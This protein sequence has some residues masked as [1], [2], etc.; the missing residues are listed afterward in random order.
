MD[1]IAENPDVPVLYDTFE[2]WGDLAATGGPGRD[3]P[4]GYF[5]TSLSDATDHD[6]IIHKALTHAMRLFQLRSN[7]SVRPAH[8]EVWFGLEAA[9][10]AARTHEVRHYVA[11]GAGRSREMAPDLG[12]ALS[13]CGLPDVLYG[14][15]VVVKT[16]PADNRS[17]AV[18]IRSSIAPVVWPRFV[19]SHWL[20]RDVLNPMPSERGRV[21]ETPCTDGETKRT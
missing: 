11:R 21:I 20:V 14:L 7:G 19:N 15:P 17:M 10:A 2:T 4:R 9:Y 12:S 5:G 13:G 1:Q 18:R 16:F 3:W 6:P 8:L